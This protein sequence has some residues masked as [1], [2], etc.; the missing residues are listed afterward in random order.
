MEE[1]PENFGDT[2][3]ESQLEEICLINEKL[4]E[5]IAEMRQLE[6]DKYKKEK[7]ADAA[8]LQYY[9]LQVSPHFFLN[10]LNIIASLLHEQDVETVNTMI[11]SVSRHFRYVFQDYNSQVLLEE[12]LEEVSAYCNIYIIPQPLAAIKL[13]KDH[14]FRRCT[15]YNAHNTVSVYQSIGN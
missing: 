11:Y 9:Q 6:Q 14:P 3:G 1:L 4:D 10:C 15:C 7:E 5:L 8:L 13:K 12:E 2:G